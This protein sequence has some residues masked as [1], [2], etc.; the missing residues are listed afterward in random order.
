MLTACDRL[1]GRTT[2]IEHDPPITVHRDVLCV[3]TGRAKK[4][5]GLFDQGG[6]LIADAG[7]FRAHPDRVSLYPLLNPLPHERFDYAPDD[8]QYVF[9]GVLTGHYGHFITNSLARVW[10]VSRFDRATTKFVLLN[11]G[12]LSMPLAISWL[13]EILGAFGLDETNLL[14]FARPTRFREIVVPA[15]AFEEGGFVHAVFGA[16]CGRAGQM[17]TRGRRNDGPPVFLTKQC[18]ASGVSKVTN[19]AEMCE[20]LSAAG[21]QIV[22]PE[23]LSVSEQIR[24][25]ADRDAVL[26][27]AGSA[28]HTAVFA[29]GRQKIELHTGRARL[30]NQALIDAANGGRTTALWPAQGI[31]AAQPEAG[32]GAA[33]RLSDPVA[34]ARELLRHII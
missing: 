10:A 14:N 3:P 17:L 33:Y 21:V 18:L 12:P 31:E 2:F 29:P 7:Y 13:R 30:S 19:E 5:E 1:L 15:P 26:G 22:A 34:V 16:A 11:H 4:D 6:K 8:V 28:M 25:F 32:F 23:T 20:H 9:L 27:M 24:L